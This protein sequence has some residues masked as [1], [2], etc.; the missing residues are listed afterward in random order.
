MAYSQYKKLSIQAYNTNNNTWGANGVT[1]DDLNTGCFGPLD[2]ILGGISTF[3]NPSGSISLSFTAGGTGDVQQA[4]WRFTGTITADTTVTTAVGNATTYLNG[5]YLWSNTTSGSFTI[6]LT[7]ANGSVVLP[8][9]RRGILYVNNVNSIAPFIVAIAGSSTADPIPGNGTTKMLFAMASPPSGW[10]QVV[11]YNNY[12][13]RLVSGTGAGTGGSTGFT[14]VFTSRT[15]A[16]TNS[17]S[18]AT[19]TVPKDGWTASG[20]FTSG[21]LAVEA[22]SSNPT[23]G[24]SSDRSIT[25]TAAAQ[26]FTGTAMD[27]AVSYVDTILA[28]RD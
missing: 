23:S 12:A 9:G 22:G 2:Y 3:T 21:L 17:S 5:Y 25:G 11:S 1:G 8:Q 27:F 13:L 6:T 19:S 16:G 18:V 26:T 4:M 10:T 7:T 20:L 24:Q 15:P 14:S 28:S